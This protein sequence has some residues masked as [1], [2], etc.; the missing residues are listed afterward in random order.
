MAAVRTTPERKPSLTLEEA[1]ELC[2]Y[3]PPRDLSYKPA[4]GIGLGPG[5]VAVRLRAGVCS[6]GSAVST[7]R[8]YYQTARKST[9]GKAPNNQLATKTQVR[10]APATCPMKKPHRYRPG[11][12]AL[13]LLVSAILALQESAEAYL[14]GLFEDTNLC[15]IH[16]KRVTVMPKDMQDD[17][18]PP[19]TPVHQP[20]ASSSDNDASTEPPSPTSDGEPSDLRAF[21]DAAVA[22]DLVSRAIPMLS[23][24]GINVQIDAQ[25]L[26]DNRRENPQQG[27][28]SPVSP[29]CAICTGFGHTASY[30]PNLSPYAS[31]IH[32]CANCGGAKHHED[33]CTSCQRPSSPSLEPHKNKLTEICINCNGRGHYGK[34]CFS[35]TPV[36]PTST[37]CANCGGYGHQD[38]SCP[39]PCQMTPPLESPPHDSGDN[40]GDEDTTGDIQ[41]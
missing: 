34:Q 20:P 6:D 25:V 1:G 7:G 11:T 5:L 18:V 8:D 39:N 19:S 3:V 30:C 10:N 27:L 4:Y 17:A 14:V 9:G 2:R 26:P 40:S 13:R 32:Y 41:Y 12:V 16:A 37:T 28:W 31:Q 24:F 36:T 22:A 29:Q 33:Q 23:A 15:A 38:P 35:S 21:Q